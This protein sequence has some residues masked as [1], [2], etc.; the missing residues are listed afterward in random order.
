MKFEGH[1]NSIHILTVVVGT[2][3][4]INLAAIVLIIKYMSMIR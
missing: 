1:C 3:S 4:T 2:N